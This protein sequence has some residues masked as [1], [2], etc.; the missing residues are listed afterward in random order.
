MVYLTRED[1]VKLRRLQL[2]SRYLERV[3]DVFLFCCFSGLRYS[4]ARNLRK[5]DIKGDH[6][7]VTTIK[8][9]D[10]ITIE[11]NKVTNEIIRKYKDVF[12][13]D[14]KALPCSSNQAMNK[15]LKILCRM[16]G[17]DDDVRI[18]QYRGGERK[19]FF[20]HKWQRICTHTGRRTF[21]V[22]ALSL[23]IPPS[24]VMKWT[25]H[26]SY[27]AMQP[28]ID[29]VDAEKARSMEKFNHLL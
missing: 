29:I 15:R 3:R 21:I 13:P 14:G 2:T 7:E 18:T 10:S 6:L 24:V 17:L 9:G 19:D 1:I 5:C 4:D 11:L 28:Y 25:G 8:T 26:S 16:A 27:R 22:Q 23:G 20:F 12:I